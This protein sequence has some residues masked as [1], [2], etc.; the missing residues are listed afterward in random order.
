MHSNA[1]HC[2]I[3][4]LVDTPHQAVSFMTKLAC[5]VKKGQTKSVHHG[6]RLLQK[7]RKS[8]QHFKH[9]YYMSITDEAQFKQVGQKH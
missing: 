1:P 4:F 9:V 8:V 5:M 3:Y 2:F 7:D 6:L